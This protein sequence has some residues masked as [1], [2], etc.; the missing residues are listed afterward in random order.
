ME[1]FLLTPMRDRRGT[2]ELLPEKLLAIRKFL[3]FGEVEMAESL[4]SD[5]ISRTGR[6]CNI[7]PGRISEYENG[8]LEPNLLVLLA[9]ARLGKVH[10]ELIADDRF[11]VQEFREQLGK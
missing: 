2:Q 9:Y 6:P 4:T 10:L 8:R 5:I 11:T 3:T 1:V 7:K